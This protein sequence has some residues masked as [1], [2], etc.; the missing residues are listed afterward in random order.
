MPLGINHTR[1][2]PVVEVLPREGGWACRPGK[3]STA[4]AGPAAPE[5]PLP[6]EATAPERLWGDFRLL[7][8]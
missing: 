2:R 1:L 3:A 6:E 8:K 4:W 5:P 7:I